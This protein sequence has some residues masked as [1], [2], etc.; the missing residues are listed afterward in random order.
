MRMKKR[1][2]LQGNIHGQQAKKKK[3]GDGAG[4]ARSRLKKTACRP[5]IDGKLVAKGKSA[6]VEVQT[7]SPNTEGGEWRLDVADGPGWDKQVRKGG[8]TELR[9]MMRGE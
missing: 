7:I 3:E 5:I 4:A 8:P 2:G 6:V 1:S 9:R